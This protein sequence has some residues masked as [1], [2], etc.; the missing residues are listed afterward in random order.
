MLNRLQEAEAELARGNAKRAFRILWDEKVSAAVRAD[1]P[2]LEAIVE[3]AGRIASES[4]GKTATE[5]SRL[6]TSARSEL[7]YTRQIGGEADAR[8]M[9]ERREAVE[10]RPGVL[11]VVL[12]LVVYGGSLTAGI[13]GLSGSVDDNSSHWVW[14]TV[15]VLFALIHVVAGFVAGRWWAVILGAIP[16]LV[17]I[18][19]TVPEYEEDVG[20]AQLA[21]ILF[22]FGWPFL[23]GPLIAVGIGIRRWLDRRRG[24]GV[25]PPSRSAPAES[26][27]LS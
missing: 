17:A 2:Q 13:L 12:T 7:Q 6:L 24:R 15:L 16:G 4:G 18:S 9:T 5:A 1:V 23:L 20:K 3:L 27:A 10:Q 21:V 22:I 26:R 8:V 25:L 11:S 19:L 14:G